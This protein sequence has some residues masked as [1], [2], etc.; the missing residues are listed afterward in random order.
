MQ[1]T[2]NSKAP[3]KLMFLFAVTCARYEYT[4]T[5]FFGQK[6]GL[7]LFV[8]IVTAHRSLRNS[9]TKIMNLKHGNEKNMVVNIN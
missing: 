8:K 3:R 7:W 5:M 2:E 4:K 1:I 6:F 9:M